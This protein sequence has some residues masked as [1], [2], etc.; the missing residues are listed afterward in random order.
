VVE[1]LLSLR[2]L[3]LDVATPRGTAHLLRGATLAIGHGRILGLVGESGSGKSTLAAALLGLR[4][5]DTSRIAG[6]ALF[7]GADLLKLDDAA[8]RAY[9]GRR[10]AMIFQDAALSPLFTIGTQLADVA[11]RR[12]PGLGRG[13]A[14]AKAQAML[15]SVGLAD[16]GARLGA[17]PHQLSGGQRQRVMIAMA[18]LAKPDLLIADEPTSALD[19]T[20]EAGIMALF[21]DLRRGFAG[22]MLFISHD[23]G[24]VAEL[25]D[26]LAVIYGGVVVESG[27]A[28]ALLARPKHPYTQALLDCAR[29][30]DRPNGRAAAIPGET[31]DPFA[32][33]TACVFAPRCPHAAPACLA[34]QP[35]LAEVAPGRRSACIRADE[36]QP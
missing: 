23:L 15:A 2:E 30:G 13:A 31:P 20:V 14:L 6:E 25:C 3:S 34:G 8:M 29:D 16:P 12:E 32:P 33:L 22:A 21:A 11:R 24:L 10:I 5:A 36:V 18:L 27:P 35:P 28:A 19:A 1:P 9:R 4:P 7:D 17:Y 26:D